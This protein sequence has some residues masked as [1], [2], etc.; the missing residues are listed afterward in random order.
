[1]LNV[2]NTAFVDNVFPS[3]TPVV[4]DAEH[5]FAT[6]SDAIIAAATARGPA[7][8]PWRILVRPGTYP[9][10]AAGGVISP[11]PNMTIVGSGAA[12]IVNAR[13]AL[14]LG[15]TGV[16]M[17]DFVQNIPTGTVNLITNSNVTVRRLS[18]TSTQSTA[19][20]QLA[21]ATPVLTI[22][23]CS[24]AVTNA[25]AGLTTVF[26]CGGAG[27]T[28]TLDAN[29]LEITTTGYL[30]QV[31]FAS[32]ITSVTATVRNMT[33]NATTT[34]NSIVQD[35]LYLVNFGAVT[36][37][38][39]NILVDDCNH[40]L[41]YAAGG[42]PTSTMV[43]LEGTAGTP[44]A[45]SRYVVRDSLFQFVGY[46]TASTV[47][48][49]D[50]VVTTGNFIQLLDNKWLGLTIAGPAVTTY[51]PRPTTGSA[52]VVY[53]GLSGSGSVVTSGGLQTGVTTIPSATT[54]YTVL[55]GDAIIV[56]APTG[57]ATLTMTSSSVFIGK[58]VTVYNSNA[59]GPQITISCSGPANG[60][61]VNFGSSIV[62]QTYDGTNWF[63]ASNALAVQVATASSASA[64]LAVGASITA[65]ANLT[66]GTAVLGGGF[67]FTHT[68][69]A[70]VQ[71]SVQTSTATT[72]T[73]W[74][75]TIVNTGTVPIT[76][77]NLTVTAI[78]F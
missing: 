34:I 25:T 10:T 69:G 64:S 1:V 39:V 42:T 32:G 49:A 15:M 59:I 73:Q 27:S 11:F 19:V 58:W 33:L 24:I 66:T 48:S 22:S 45:G 53:E 26:T 4:E 56:W 52:P 67:D 63:I 71:W 13:L 74:T 57:S 60:T 16:F 47:S 55:D 31:V 70:G 14:T 51:V 46:P 43:Y 77:V 7:T 61:L 36:V 20:F 38:A 8:T 21:G 17:E 54:A 76:G 68:A 50:D 5:P 6:I 29:D 35:G 40:N 9:E 12:T 28:A 41:T 2:A 30:P 23:N 37:P 78:G 75:T 18:I 72:L 65:S 3:A 44:P 62:L